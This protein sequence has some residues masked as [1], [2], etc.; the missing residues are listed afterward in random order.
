MSLSVSSSG[1]AGT[2]APS[3]M[4]NSRIKRRSVSQILHGSPRLRRTI[5]SRYASSMP[6][7]RI[8]SSASASPVSPPASL[9]PLSSGV[10]SFSL[11][12]SASA[13]Y[14]A[15]HSLAAP[16]FSVTPTKTLPAAFAARRVSCSSE[17][18]TGYKTPSTRTF[19]SVF[20]VSGSPFSLFHWKPVFCVSL[21]TD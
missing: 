10:F 17:R 13:T 9:I 18:I 12:G 7:R 5:R 1:S 2:L 16:P 3:A 8:K 6:A 4:V 11:S 19:R 15:P 14:S 21:R 20:I